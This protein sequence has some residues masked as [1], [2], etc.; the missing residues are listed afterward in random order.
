MRLKTTATLIGLILPLTATA[1][2][3]KTPLREVAAIDNQMFAVAMAIE[4]S[5][6]CT[7]IRPRTVKGLAFLWDLAGQAK[8]M[9]YTEAE[10]DAY[11]K[12]DAEKARMRARGEAY[13]RDKGLDPK[14]KEDLGKLGRMEMA[15]SSQIGSFLK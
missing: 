5:D 8:S 13:M 11:R 10:I 4:I 14:K 3:A 9:G 6:N 15:A 2:A 7:D 1:S 12:S